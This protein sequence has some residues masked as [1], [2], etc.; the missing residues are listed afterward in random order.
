MEE[1]YCSKTVSDAISAP[2]LDNVEKPEAFFYNDNNNNNIII[3]FDE[4]VMS[5]FVIIYLDFRYTIVVPRVP[6]KR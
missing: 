6:R 1:N 4:L 5:L 3:Q 2:V